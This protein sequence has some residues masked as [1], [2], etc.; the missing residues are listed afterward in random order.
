MK[1]T[2][3]KLI[4]W[5]NYV[6][7]ILYMSWHTNEGQT[8]IESTIPLLI[9]SLMLIDITYISSCNIREN[10]VISL[11]CG[12]LALDSWYVLLSFEGDMIENFVFIALSPIIWYVSIRFILMFLFQ[13]SGYKFRKTTNVIMLITCIGSLIGVGISDR[14]FACLYGLQF[15]IN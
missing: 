7:L 3:I 1:N 13:G 8:G 6:L 5:L 2:A 12:L 10:K 4:F 11:F 9:S 14:A 15:L